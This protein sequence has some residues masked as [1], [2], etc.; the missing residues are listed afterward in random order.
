MGTGNSRLKRHKD[1]AELKAPIIYYQRR[2]HCASFR[3]VP[4]A[5]GASLGAHCT[6]RSPDTGG[7]GVLPSAVCAVPT[8]CTPQLQCVGSGLQDRGAGCPLRWG[9]GSRAVSFPVQRVAEL[10][11]L[12][13]HQG[14]AVARPHLSLHWQ[15]RD[16]A[17]NRHPRTPPA[18]QC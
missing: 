11:W 12:V 16:F 15:G 18:A 17:A 4:I 6:A 7:G 5:N 2:D 3:A 1:G 13:F 8:P 9:A 10:K 14:T